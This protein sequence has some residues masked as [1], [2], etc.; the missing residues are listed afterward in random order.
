MKKEIR[1]LKHLYNSN[2]RNHAGRKCDY[3][4]NIIEKFG[5]ITDEV[6]D[7]YGGDLI[8]SEYDHSKNKRLVCITNKGNKFIENYY[9]EKI[10]EVFY[11]IFGVSSV[12][13]AIFA[14]LAITCKK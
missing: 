10:K 6:S 14:V 13:A 8:L 1:I 3:E 9:Y 2:I 4:E 11:W 7:L 12:V 5:L